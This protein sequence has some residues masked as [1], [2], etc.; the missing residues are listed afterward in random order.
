MHDQLY[1]PSG[2]AAAGS[3]RIHRA[4]EVRADSSYQV[5][6]KPGYPHKGLIVV[7]TLGGEGRLRLK[8]REL[9]CA[10][11]TLALIDP[12][13]VMG[14][15]CVAPLWSFWWLECSGHFPPGL[16]CNT[17][18]SI[19]RMPR[20]AE[21]LVEIMR[22][23][24][25]DGSGAQLAAASFLHLLY[26]WQDAW[27][28]RRTVETPGRRRMRDVL[29]LMQA[30]CEKPLSIAELAARAHLCEGR[31]RKV[32]ARQTGLP[33]KAWYEELRLARAAAWLRDSD[34][35][36]S[37]IAESLHYSSPFHFS[38][39]FRKRYG[40]PPSRFRPSG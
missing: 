26:R 40:L 10:A 13:A 12:S 33:P 5:R 8:T 39:A 34:R 38:R 31:F 28:G 36:L 2:R 3:L 35:K 29:T 9:S 11:E 24:E 20:E 15:G 6:W 21:T 32:F 23:L 25:R 1:S 14:Y 37:E 18:F 19:R 7:R 27:V 30:T 4:W 17:L 22:L 16:A